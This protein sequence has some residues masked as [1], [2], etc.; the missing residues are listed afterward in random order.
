MFVFELFMALPNQIQEGILSEH[1][2]GK[3]ASRIVFVGWFPRY[4]SFTRSNNHHQNNPQYHRTYRCRWV[5]ENRS[6][7]QHLQQQKI[8]KSQITYL[9]A[10]FLDK[11]RSKEPMAEMTEA[12]SRGMISAFSIR[13]NSSP[14]NARYMISLLVHLLLEVD[15]RRRPTAVPPNTPTTVKMVS[16]FLVT[17]LTNG[18]R[19]SAMTDLKRGEKKLFVSQHFTSPTSNSTKPN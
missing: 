18:L 15:L 11:L 1:V 17:H 19:S 14:G 7:K 6:E 13:R 4:R 9:I 5:V 12:M 2:S 10:I 3:Y 8:S 16:K